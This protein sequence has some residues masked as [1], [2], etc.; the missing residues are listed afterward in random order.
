MLFH[1]R[2]AGKVTSGIED[3]GCETSSFWEWVSGK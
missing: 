2:L 1:A 3:E